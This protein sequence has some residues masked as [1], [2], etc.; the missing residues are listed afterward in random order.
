MVTIVPSE[1]QTS[2]KC[3]RCTCQGQYGHLGCNSN[4]AWAFYN[5]IYFQPKVWVMFFWLCVLV[6]VSIVPQNCKL[7][8]KCCKYTCQKGWGHLACKSNA[9]WA[10]HSPKKLSFDAWVVFI[11]LCVLV[12]VPIVPTELQTCAKQ[13]KCT[14]QEGWG[15]LSRK[16]SATWA[17][18]KPKCIHP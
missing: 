3:F 12:M 11:W 17:L 1:L 8:L 4:S 2:A 14:C 5:P 15:H 16:S 6:M 13:C 10:F 18:P 7:R 9:I